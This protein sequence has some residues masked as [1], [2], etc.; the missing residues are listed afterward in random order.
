L[1]IG[2]G[3]LILGYYDAAGML[4]LAGKV[5]TGFSDKVLA[6][7]RRR[8]EQI[9]SMP[10]PFRTTISCSHWIEPQRLLRADRVRP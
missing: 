7:L 5:G 3:L 8:V 4:Y 6:E 10:R 9:P 2:I 1:R